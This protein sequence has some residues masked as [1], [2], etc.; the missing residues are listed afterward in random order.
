MFRN[1]LPHLKNKYMVATIAFLVWM[2]FFDRNSFINQIKLVS[3]LNGLDQQ[4]EYYQ[5]EIKKDSAELHKL[6][7][8][9]T[10]LIKFAREKYLMKKDNED[11]FL[12]VE[13]KK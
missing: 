8:D 2:M 6:L 11:I 9:T 10:T 1:L 13:E 4:K 5:E 12:I 7:T 3:T